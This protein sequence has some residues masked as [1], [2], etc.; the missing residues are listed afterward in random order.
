MVK[1]LIPHFSGLQTKYAGKKP[2]AFRNKYSYKPPLSDP[3]P[4]EAGQRPLTTSRGRNAFLSLLEKY[5][6][7]PVMNGACTVPRNPKTFWTR[8]LDATRST[9]CSS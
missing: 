8:V 5:K 9:K 7:N 2:K 6:G 4:E 3:W 1:T